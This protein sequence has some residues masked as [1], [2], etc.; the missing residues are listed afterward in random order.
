MS[1]VPPAFHRDQRPA[2][3]PIW[4]EALLGLDWLRLRS[5][6]V[7]YGFDVPRGDGAPVVVVPG[8]LGSDWYLL[9][10]YWWLRRIGY[11]PYLSG[12]GRN[13]ECFDVLSG[14]LF[15]TIERARRETGRPVH[16]VGHSLG[17]ML[18]RSATIA[19][20]EAVASVITLGSPF[21]GIRCHPLLI[22]VS[23]TV[24]D[25]IHRRGQPA[26]C[27]TGDCPCV[28]V[29]ALSEPLP[30]DIPQSAIYTRTDG[31]VD[32][33]ACRNDDPETDFE[34]RSTHIGLVFSAA[35]FRLIAERLAAV[36]AP[37]A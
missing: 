34:V 12:I 29:Q 2:A 26:E 13:A 1:I 15:E 22:R 37:R 24:R 35:A 32:W 4:R 20:P 17:G 6:P 31:I 18:S 25:R 23:R 3:V 11:R 28:P 36:P 7:C 27:F 30:A 19:R 10:L 21:Q 14:R 33:R 16:L 8:F 9:E 5:S